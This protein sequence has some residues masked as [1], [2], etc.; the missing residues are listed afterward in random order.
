M[1]LR[2]L[3]LRVESG[4]SVTVL[5]GRDVLVAPGAL[6]VRL[7]DVCLVGSPAAVV[8][9]LSRALQQ[10][11]SAW[12]DGRRVGA[13]GGPDGAGPQTQVSLPP[14]TEATEVGDARSRLARGRR[15][16][17]LALTVGHRS[18][19]L[20]PLVGGGIETDVYRMDEGGGH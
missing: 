6:H 3:S 18:Q 10:C 7:G 8:D 12:G 17:R 11:Y 5:Y 9:L 15:R 14:V 2:K 1:E 20:S 16:S 13:D 4:E 19:T